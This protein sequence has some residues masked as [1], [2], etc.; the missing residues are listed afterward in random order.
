MLKVKT[1]N[2]PISETLLYR[3]KAGEKQALDDLITRYQ[4]GVFSRLRASL[5]FHTTE[6]VIQETN[7]AVARG[8]AGFN[9]AT[10]DQFCSFYRG[11]ADHKRVDAQR[12]KYHDRK[13]HGRTG[14]PPLGGAD[15]DLGSCPFDV[16]DDRQQKSIDIVLKKEQL[17]RLRS[18]LANLDDVDRAIVR[19]RCDG[20]KLS[21][22]AASL[23][24][25][26]STVSF[27]YKKAIQR[28]NS[29]AAEMGLLDE[30]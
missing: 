19:L 18:L 3:A 21:E 30:T 6:D 23:S 11:I 20:A 4:P 14:S 7:L 2:D 26:V 8:I 1:T 29:L 17:M 28:L 5:D 15:D 9:G 25:S 27:R 13:G 12:R 24:C 10:L 16:E 22:I